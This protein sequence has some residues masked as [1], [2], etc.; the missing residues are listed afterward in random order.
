MKKDAISAY[1]IAQRFSGIHEIDGAMSNP[2]ILAMIRLD[3]PDANDDEIHWCSAFVNYVTWLLRLPRSKSLRARS[4]LEVGKVI[5]LGKAR[6]GFDV[7]VMKTKDED[8][9]PDVIDTRGHVG[10]YAGLEEDDILLLGGNQSDSVKIS[11]Y[12]RKR[13]LGVRRLA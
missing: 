7:V 10:F 3:R 9:G 11:R 2:Q 5:E 6:P 4:W 1:D 8:P 13:L 12:P